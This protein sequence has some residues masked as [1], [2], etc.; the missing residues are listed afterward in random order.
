MLD[1][2]AGGLSLSETFVPF[3]AHKP[4]DTAGESFRD[5]QG[6]EVQPPL[7]LACGFRVQDKQNQLKMNVEENQQALRAGVGGKGG[8]SPAFPREAKRAHLQLA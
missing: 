7:L 6:L 3:P 1:L 8:G 2:Q 4:P 5:T